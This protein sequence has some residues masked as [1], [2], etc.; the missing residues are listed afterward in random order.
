MLTKLMT[1]GTALLLTT[2]ALAG[3]ANLQVDNHWEASVQVEV[4]GYRL[5]TLAPHSDG[6]FQVRPGFHTVTFRSMNGTLLDRTDRV[7]HPRRTTH[8]NVDTPITTLVVTNTGNTPLYVQSSHPLASFGD[9]WVEPGASVNTRVPA[10]TH[11]L[12]ASAIGHRGR[13]QTVDTA[14]VWAEPGRPN[15][16][17]VKHV[18]APTRLLV[19][20]HERTA[21][22]LYVDGE[23]RGHLAPGAVMALDVRPGRHAIGA[24]GRHGRRIEQTVIAGRGSDTRI[25]LFR[26]PAPARPAAVAYTGRHRPRR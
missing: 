13:L 14:K 3:R 23:Y 12:T 15:H 20:N 10:G 11:H 1:A 18:L 5:G 17:Q 7:L 9:L 24:F 25:D 22:K 4:D 19:R 21:V 16:A 6:W 8:M 2:P 26:S